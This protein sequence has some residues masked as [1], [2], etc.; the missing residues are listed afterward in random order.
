[1]ARHQE[2]PQLISKI[3]QEPGIE[4]EAHVAVFMTQKRWG[5]N[6]CG[7]RK[8]GWRPAPHTA[9]ISSSSLLA[10]FAPQSLVNGPQLPL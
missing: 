1:M 8:S 6:S 7:L 10:T 4:S 5:L 2:G 3:V 9:E